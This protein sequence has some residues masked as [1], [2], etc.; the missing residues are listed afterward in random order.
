MMAKLNFRCGKL[1]FIEV[2]GGEF[3]VACDSASEIFDRK[4]TLNLVARAIEQ[5]A[6]G[7]RGVLGAAIGDYRHGLLGL[8]SGCESLRKLSPQ[9]YRLRQKKSRAKT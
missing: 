2:F 4:N 9:P 3:V 1:D 8:N 7:M 5:R 6:E